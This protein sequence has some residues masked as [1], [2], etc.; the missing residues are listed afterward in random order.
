M[1]PHRGLPALPAL[2]AR[3]C[4]SGRRSAAHPRA[5]SSSAL[6]SRISYIT[7]SFFTPAHRVTVSVPATISN[8]G[9]GFDCFGFAIDVENRVI[10]ERADSF[11]IEIFGESASLP[12]N[13][14]NV[15]VRMTAKAMHTLG[16][17]MPPLRFECHNAVPPRKGFGSSSAAVVAGLATGLAFGGK[18]LELPST[19]QLLLQ[20]AAEQE[21][22]ADNIAP[23]I[24]GGFQIS[25]RNERQWI[26]QRVF[27]PSGLQ[28][29]LFIP[30]DEIL[31]AEARSVLPKTTSYPDAIF[32]ISRAA[33][34]VNCFATSQFDPLRFAMED[35]LHQRYRTHMFPFE[36]LIDAAVK[37]GAHAAFLAGAGPSVVAICGGVGISDPGSDTMSQFLAESVSQA[38]LE[39]ARGIGIPGG[40]HIAM[41]SQRG[42]SSSGVDAN[43]NVL[44]P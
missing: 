20:L 35:R 34:L 14:E 2:R 3:A 6:H 31:S 18:D 39:A 13:E 1:A 5:L 27:I 40:V 7:E 37:A 43:K 8:L 38:F 29:C 28:L 33:M 41:P 16:M 11:S 26:S 17:E 15:I 4:A 23:A 21:G 19:K 44:W 22:Q 36:P 30:D 12:Q 24:F 9:P 42:L 25:C 32:N 10:V